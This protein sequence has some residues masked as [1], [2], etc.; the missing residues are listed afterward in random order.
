MRARNAISL[1][2]ETVQKCKKSAVIQECQDALWIYHTKVCVEF[3][4][5]C[6]Y[7]FHF[8]SLYIEKHCNQKK[9]NKTE[10]VKCDVRERI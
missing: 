7:I 9:Q 1:S 4:D 8:F 2:E 6:F 10:T 5:Q 3:S